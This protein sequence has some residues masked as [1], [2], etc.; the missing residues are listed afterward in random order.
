MYLRT[1]IAVLALALTSAPTLAAPLS[2]YGRLPAIEDATISP[3]GH[4]VALVVTN[5]E[6]RFI[7]VQEI[8]SGAIT[9]KGFV[10]DHKIR[11]VQWAGD[12]HL[13]LVSSATETVHTIRHGRREW[14]FGTAIDVTTK[15][16]RPIMRNSQADLNAIFDTPI[17]RV[18]KGEPTVFVQGLVFLSNRGRLSLFRYDLDSGSNRLVE[19]G[20]EDTIDWLVDAQGQP[21]AQE[22]YSRGDGVWS[23]KLRAGAGWREVASAVAPVDRPSLVGVGRDAASVLYTGK[24][25]EG[26]PVWREARLDGAPASDPIPTVDN[27]MPLRDRKDGRMIGHYALVGDEGHYR[28]FDPA[29]AKAWKAIMAAYPGDF[30]RLAS[31]SEDRRKVV[32][33][34]DSP[35]EGPAYALVDMDTRKATWLGAQ[36]SDLQP[37]DIAMQQA[38]SFKAA[39]GL[40]LSGYLTLPRGR[41]AKN[42]PLVVFPHG[43]PAARDTPGF[44][45]WAQG[46]ASRGYAVL[47]V[48]FR[49]S[50]GLGS[51]LL[52]AGYGQWGRKMQTDLSDGVRHLA[53]QG[54]I[55]PKRVCIVGASYGGYAALAGATIDRG[56]YRCAVAVSGVADL[57]TMIAHSRGRGGVSATRYWTRF[58]G[59]EDAN[60]PVL[61]TL[62]PLRLADRADIP[63]LLIHGKDDTVVPIT[64]SRAMAEAL[65]KA[66]KSVELVIQEGEDHW[67]SRGDTRLQTLEATVAFLEKHN[68]P[69]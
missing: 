17:V 68:P 67:L 15:R 66:G 34:V 64:Q 49:G 22:L 12:K 29:D 1:L 42:L 4:A 24:D 14:Y 20:G 39:D 47:Q 52:R 21:F 25:G 32:V 33:W 51:E 59:A 54:L 61:A 3:S 9:L 40:A 41:P 55:D 36:F 31:W 43:G 5:G 27:Q 37:A 10:G 58:M 65:H 2:A 13:L 60:D 57:K 30:V 69:N 63:I 62:S 48:N 19:T 38:I 8:A 50:D 16:I 7:V 46:M 28:F 26:R 11:D 53:G 23:L 56:V 35:T 44:D 18:Y 45:W 6:Q